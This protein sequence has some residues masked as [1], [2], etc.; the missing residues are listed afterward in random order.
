MNGLPED[1]DETRIKME[2]LEERIMAIEGG[3]QLCFGGVVDLCLVLDVKIP[4]KFKALKFE[5]YQGTTCP[6]NH[7]TMY[8]RK[9]AAHMHDEKLLIHFFQDSL[10]GI[11]L[12]WYMHLEPSRI[13]SWKDLVKAFIK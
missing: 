5:K 10:G 8:Y 1:G 6:K 7:L 12:N 13:G 9:M 3:E 4:P 11:T 2:R